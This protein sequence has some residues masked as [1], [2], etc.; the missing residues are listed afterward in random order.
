MVTL[1]DL[2][3]MQAGRDAQFEAEAKYRALV[4]HIP[5]VVYL[6][7][8]DENADSIYVSPQIR[9]LVGIEPDE[10]LAD[11]YAGVTTCIPT[12][13]IAPGASTRTPTTATPRSTTSTGWCTRTGPSAGSW[14]RPS[15]STTSTGTRG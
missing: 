5:A 15:R 7:P 11:P 10:W 4:E 8:V 3:E 13:S 1:R 2:S 12:T 9:D 6:D 14:S